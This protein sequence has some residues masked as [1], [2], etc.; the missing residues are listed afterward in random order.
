MPGAGVANDRAGHDADR[1][2]ASDEH[3]LAQDW[4]RERG[5]DGVAEW[6]EDGGHVAVDLGIVV[7]DI[8][9]RQGDVLGESA[10][11]ID[12]DAFRVL[13]QMPAAGKTIPAAAAD[14][15]PF[16]ADD[17]AG[18]KVGH[19]RADRDDLPD[20]LVADDHRHRD[21]LPRPVIP[22]VDVYVGATDAGAV[23][24]DEHVVDPD[25]R[26]RHVLQPQS[27]FRLVFDERFHAWFSA[28]S[29]RRL[30]DSPAGLGNAGIIAG[31]TDGAAISWAA[32]SM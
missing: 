16:A 20:E 31:R 23:H 32:V 17:F 25:V 4:E 11:P 29:S 30:E 26:L 22:F 27:R 2:G 7:P 9:H 1:P 21:R 6:V 15:V 24:L 19:V 5:V 28:A 8:G 12:A 10:R 18:M 3:V 14:D 13:A